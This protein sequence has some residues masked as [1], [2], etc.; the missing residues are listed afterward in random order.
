MSHTSI[1]LTLK[2]WRQKNASQK[3][4]F[5]VYLAKDVDTNA[6]FLE[7]LDVVVI[8]VK[9]VKPKRVRRFVMMMSFVTPQHGNI[10]V[11][12]KHQHCIRKN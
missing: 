12:K 6:S 7:M 8:F 9:R 10:K 3:G 4:G 2:V 11:K 1:N 5:E